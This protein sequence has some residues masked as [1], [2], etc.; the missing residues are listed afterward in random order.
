[1]IRLVST[2]LYSKK[3]KIYAYSFLYSYNIEFLVNKFKTKNF[4]FQCQIIYIYNFLIN[5]PIK[6]MRE[7]KKTNERKNF[8]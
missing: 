8:K 1:M 5:E 3:N 4:R 2:L 6:N 7:E